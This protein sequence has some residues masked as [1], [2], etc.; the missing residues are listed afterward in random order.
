MHSGENPYKCNV[1]DKRC[2]QKGELIV[3]IRKH[4]TVKPL[5][6]TICNRGFTTKGA[7]ERHHVTHTINAL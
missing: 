5:K 7:L 6:Y 2:S 1:C 4:A 3:H